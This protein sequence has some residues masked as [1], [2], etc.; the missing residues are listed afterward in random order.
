VEAGA[1]G[2][3]EADKY[4][5]KINLDLAASDAS[6]ITNSG[7]IASDVSLLGAFADDLDAGKYYTGIGAK[8][9]APLLQ[10][11]LASKLG[12]VSNIAIA[13]YGKAYKGAMSDRE[14]ATMIEGAIN[15]SNV[16]EK[17]LAANLRDLA[18]VR[19]LSLDTA[20]ARMAWV[21]SGKRA[22][23]FPLPKIDNVIERI[24]ARTDNA[25]KAKASAPAKKISEMTNEELA[26]RRAELMN[27]KGK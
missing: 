16:D 20:K 13:E 14:F 4:L 12:R 11:E 8:W 26:A 2:K 10:P 25:G 21:A 5:D 27:K 15:P 24:K 17:V 19:Q 1:S 23:D 18:Y 7:A 9:T 6:S 3:G 22:I